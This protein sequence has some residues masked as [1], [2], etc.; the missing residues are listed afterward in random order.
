[1]LVPRVAAA[2]DDPPDG[3]IQLGGPAVFEVMFRPRIAGPVLLELGAFGV[4]GGGL[5]GNASVGAIVE[6]SQGHTVRPYV[7]MGASAATGCGESETGRGCSGLVFGCTRAGVGVDVGPDPSN[8]VT[9]DVG[10]WVGGVDNDDRGL[11]PF[12]IPMGGV[13]YYW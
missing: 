1:M 11:R 5:A 10:G 8:L 12:L 4:A 3:G 2:A 13:G 9:L 7:A 6:L